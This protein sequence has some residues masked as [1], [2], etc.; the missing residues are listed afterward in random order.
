MSKEQN[1]ITGYYG[2][3]KRGH[4]EVASPDG[5]ILRTSPVKNVKVV[6][7]QVYIETRNSIYCTYAYY[8]FGEM[9]ER[10]T[11]FCPFPEKVKAEGMRYPEKEF[12]YCRADHDGYRWYN[13]WFKVKDR[14]N[15]DT[16]TYEL[17]EVYSCF[18]ESIK[19][20][21]LLRA[22]CQK[23]CKPLN[24]SEYNGFL[25][26]EKFDYWF[27]FILRRGDYNCY[28]NVFEK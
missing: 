27:R 8:N 23:R 19:D 9:M 21:H 15:P 2:T 25:V 3:D 5:R 24:D 13:T 10:V 20:L 14:I 1:I 12:A 7:G 11:N 26:G 17:D 22:F 18:T 6:A 16:P 28:M 4:A